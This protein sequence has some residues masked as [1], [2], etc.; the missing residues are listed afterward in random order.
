MRD[1]VL[2]HGLWVPSVVMT[3]LAARLRAAGYRCHLFGYLGAVRP[4]EAHAARLARL[5]LQVGPA[6]FVGHSL[7]GLVILEALERHRELRVGRVVLLGTPARGNFSGRRL[8]RHRWGRWFL[9]AS[10]PLWA[11]GRAAH[12]TRPEPLGVIAGSLSLGLG[13]VLGTLP[14]ANDGVVRVE[15]TEVEGMRARVV[16]RAGHSQLLVSARAAAETASFLAHAR[17]TDPR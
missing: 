12:W 6:H 8:A 11:E 10:E 14:G 15:E 2:V 17:F 5:A 9:G 1:V 3:P 16:L 7:G 4:L 13:R